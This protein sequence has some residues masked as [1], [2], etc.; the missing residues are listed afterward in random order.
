MIVKSS[1]RRKK[2]YRRKNNSRSKRKIVTN[3]ELEEQDATSDAGRGDKMNISR[4]E[5]YYKLKKMEKKSHSKVARLSKNSTKSIIYAPHDTYNR[6]KRGTSMIL[7][8]LK[9]ISKSPN[10]HP[11]NIADAIYRMR[12]LRHNMKFKHKT[13]EVEEF[14]RRKLCNQRKIDKMRQK[15]LFRNRTKM[16]DNKLKNE[17]AKLAIEKYKTKH[18]GHKWGLCNCKLI[19]DMPVSR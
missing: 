18:R 14:K 10:R 2:G 9:P 11:N 12:K 13:T 15:M 16:L 5:E 17:M 3:L 8:E 6:Q 19:S 4:L 7:M 1:R